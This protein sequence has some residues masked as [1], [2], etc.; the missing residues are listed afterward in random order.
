MFDEEKR[1]R[2]ETGFRSSETGVTLSTLTQDE[3]R[4]LRAEIDLILP[5]QKLQDID[6]EEELVEQYQKV[7]RLQEDVLNDLETPANQRAQVAGQVASTLQQLIK[8]QTEYH[9]S[10]R[11]K[12][13]ENILIRHIKKLPHDVAEA[14]INDYEAL[15][16]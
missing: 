4:Q 7:K 9:T 3:L 12:A 14:F 15:A 8:M 6:L 11:F 5:P 16:P 13:I 2:V 10:E 1:A